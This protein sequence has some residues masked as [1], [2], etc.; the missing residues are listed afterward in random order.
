MGKERMTREQK[1]DK[2]EQ[3]WTYKRNGGVDDRFAQKIKV[4]YGAGILSQPA[5]EGVF[6]VETHIVKSNN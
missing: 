6:E 2:M 1:I 4:F 3:N 5:K